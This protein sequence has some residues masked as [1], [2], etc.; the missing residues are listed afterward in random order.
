M[1]RNLC[2]RRGSDDR[3]EDDGWEQGEGASEFRDPLRVEP[4]AGDHALD[5]NAH[6]I[7]SIG[8][9]SGQSK[10]H[11]QR[12]RQQRASAR[13]RVDD[14][15]HES[16]RD[17]QGDL[18]G[19]HFMKPESLVAPAEFG[20]RIGAA[21]STSAAALQQGFACGD[22]TCFRRRRG[23]SVWR[24]AD[25]GID[26]ACAAEQGIRLLA[27][28]HRADR[29]AESMDGGRILGRKFDGALELFAREYGL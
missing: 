22:G 14:A 5:E 6:A 10:D 21:E 4:P 11:E 16:D 8:D 15:G 23:C 9:R 12:H 27:F 19:A 18:E 24:S 26:R 20:L 17:Q 13:K 28:S 1:I 25:L 3:S 2:R 29:D 7:G